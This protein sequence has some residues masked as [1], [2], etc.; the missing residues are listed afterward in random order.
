MHGV[1]NKIHQFQ[2]KQVFVTSADDTWASFGNIVCNKFEQ[3]FWKW[4]SKFKQYRYKFQGCGARSGRIQ[5]GFEG[6]NSDSDF[7]IF[8]SLIRTRILIQFSGRPV[9]IYFFLEIY[10]ILYIYWVPQ[11]L[12]QIYTVIG[13]YLHWE[14]CVIFSIFCG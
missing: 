4:Y 9:E 14:G 13:S 11:K 7:Y 12:P 6:S 2:T 5:V 8:R 1:M 10:E 3:S